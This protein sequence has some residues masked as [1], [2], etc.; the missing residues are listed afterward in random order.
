MHVF[1]VPH[2]CSFPC[3]SH[4]QPSFDTLVSAAEKAL[5]ALFSDADMLRY[6][7]SETPPLLTQSQLLNAQTVG[8]VQFTMQFSCHLLSEEQRARVSVFFL[9]F[10][11]TSK[12]SIAP[13]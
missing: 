3:S 5:D 1:S 13:F 7:S 2:I 9:T 10:P 6:I 12:S 8:Y 11:L 4:V